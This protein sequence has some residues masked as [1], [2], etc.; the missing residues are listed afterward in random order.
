M[1]QKK[2]IVNDQLKYVLSM[3]DN[4][5]TTPVLLILPLDSASGSLIFHAN[6]Y[7]QE[8]GLV[9]LHASILNVCKQREKAV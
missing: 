8:I 3:S 5:L 7:H 2:K 1:T 4:T 9:C 6:T